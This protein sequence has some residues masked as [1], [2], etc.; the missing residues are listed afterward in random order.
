MEALAFL[1]KQKWGRG[2]ADG[3]GASTTVIDKVKLP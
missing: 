1:T 2:G 3:D